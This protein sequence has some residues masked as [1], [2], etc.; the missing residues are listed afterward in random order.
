[1]EM[2]SWHT[3]VSTN[4]TIN[5]LTKRIAKFRSYSNLAYNV[6]LYETASFLQ[7]DEEEPFK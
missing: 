1:M 7:N 5:S 4:L 2:R 3:G 6:L